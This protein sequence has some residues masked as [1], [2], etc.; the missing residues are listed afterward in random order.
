MQTIPPLISIALLVCQD[1]RVL[2]LSMISRSSYFHSMA[3]MTENPIP[4]TVYWCMH[5]CLAMFR[6]HF[7]QILDMYVWFGYNSGYSWCHSLHLMRIVLHYVFEIFYRLEKSIS[8]GRNPHL[9]KCQMFSSPGCCS[10]YCVKY[11]CCIYLLRFHR[12]FCFERLPS[13]EIFKFIYC[14]YT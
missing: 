5:S 7:R 1:C 10:N 13:T 12:I 14:M 8:R 9:L 3:K 2:Y 11:I 4:L 6:V